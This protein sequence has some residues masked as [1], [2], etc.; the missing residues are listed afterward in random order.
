MY[1]KI[2]PL[3]QLFIS[4]FEN[5]EPGG[6]PSRAILEIPKCGYITILGQFPWPCTR[7]RAFAGLL[8]ESL[9][10]V[11]CLE[12]RNRRGKNENAR[13]IK[14]EKRKERKGR[15]WKF[16]CESVAHEWSYAV[17]G[18]LSLLVKMD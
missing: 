17:N 10:A 8:L 1:R 16:D 6:M 7:G 14:K 4:G 11:L 18:S 13:G 5:G 12:S 2:R 15:I 3:R 9:H